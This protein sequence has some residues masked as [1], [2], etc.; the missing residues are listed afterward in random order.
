MISEELLVDLFIKETVRLASRVGLYDEEKDLIIR[1]FGEAIKD[2]YMDER[3]IF[4]ALTGKE[5]IKA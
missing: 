3:R 1:V 2:P 4:P 5:D